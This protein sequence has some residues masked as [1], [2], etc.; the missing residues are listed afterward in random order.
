MTVESSRP[1]SPSYQFFMLVLCFYALAALAAQ[2]TIRLE[3]ETRGILDYADYAVCAFFLVDF[4]VS[5]FRAPD[6]WRYFFT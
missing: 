5:L 6:R 3:P 4:G 1:A 2:T